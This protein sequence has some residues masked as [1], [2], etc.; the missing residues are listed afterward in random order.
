[1]L[2]CGGVSLFLSLHPAATARGSSTITS[3]VLCDAI[4]VVLVFAIGTSLALVV[5]TRGDAGMLRVVVVL[6]VATVR[7][8][9]LFLIGLATQ[10]ASAN[11][12]QLLFRLIVRA[13]L[14]P[15]PFAVYS[16]IVR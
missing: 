15:W 7:V 12:E 6:S 1:M 2:S 3:T 8:V 16:L 13:C 9:V 4:G 11:N 10:C 5:R 14:E